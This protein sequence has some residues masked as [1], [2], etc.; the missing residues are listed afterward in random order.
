MELYPQITQITRTTKG[1]GE[2]TWT[3]TGR[4]TPRVTN[5]ALLPG[6]LSLISYFT[7]WNLRNLWIR[8]GADGI[9]STDYTDYTDDKRKRRKDVDINRQ[10]YAW[11]TNGALLP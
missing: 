7:P 4:H 3:L 1:K 9:V 8:S 2:K 6:V 11:V 10:A 5:G